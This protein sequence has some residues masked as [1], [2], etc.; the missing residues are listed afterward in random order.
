[1]TDGH[2]VDCVVEIG[3]PGTIAMSLKAL[4]VDG[5]VSLTGASLTPSETGFDPL[6][7]TARGITV[8]QS[9]WEPGGFRGDERGHHD[10]RLAPV[11]DKTFLFAEAKEAYRHFESRRHFG[12][13]VI[14][15][16]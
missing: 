16:G 4:A 1:M 2:G 5:H 15:R 6:L 13:V 14:T 7:L 12:K 10:G 8:G 11:I 9:A 3:G